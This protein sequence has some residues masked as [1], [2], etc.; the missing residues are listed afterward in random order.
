MSK[1]R[2]RRTA[3]Q[4]RIILS[5]LVLRDLRDPRLQD[6]TITDVTIDR[7]L[8]YADIYVNALADDSRENEVMTALK[9]ATGYFRRELASR[10]SLRTVPHLHFHWDPT[11]AHAEHINQVLY[12]LDIPAEAGPDEG[13]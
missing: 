6:L 10:L 1:I 13:K 9:G 5:Q 4:I 11:L 8:Q 7:E 12:S 3:E 2:Q